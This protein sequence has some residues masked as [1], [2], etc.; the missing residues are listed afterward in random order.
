[1]YKG[2]G[3]NTKQEALKCS[4]SRVGRES[5]HTDG[6][7]ISP[8]EMRGKAFQFVSLDCA[9]SQSLRAE[10]AILCFISVLQ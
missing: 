9:I 2:G 1:M 6:A 3:C 8:R 5:D 7:Q 10:N 4:G